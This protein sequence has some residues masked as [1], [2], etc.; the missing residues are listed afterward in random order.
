MKRS[1]KII[2]AIIVAVIF[3]GGAILSVFKQAQNTR[4]AQGTL[5]ATDGGWVAPAEGTSANASST[6]LIDTNLTTILSKQVFSNFMVLNQSGNLN[7]QTISDLTDQLSSQIIEKVPTAKVYTIADL[8]IIK[9][10]T[11]EDIKKYGN[12]FFIIR[13]NTQNAFIRDISSPGSPLLDKSDTG[14]MN[15]YILAGKLYEKIVNDLLTL[16]V[17]A[18]LVDLHL[19]ILNNYSGSAFGLKMFGQ[20]DNDPVAAIGGLNSYSKNVTVEETMVSNMAKYLRDSGIIFN[21]NE[22]GYG[23]NSL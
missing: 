15:T 2:L 4:S 10:P 9:N 7:S 3:V 11:E 8:N 13:N 22:P 1:P 5:S 20:L 23:W 21:E 6:S 12:E 14:S 18:N 16:S 19:A 17:P